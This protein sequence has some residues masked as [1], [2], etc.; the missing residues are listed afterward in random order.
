MQFIICLTSKKVQPTNRS[1]C[2]S[3]SNVKTCS[4]YIWFEKPCSPALQQYVRKSSVLA[5]NSRSSK[6]S[7]LWKRSSCQCSSTRAWLGSASRSDVEIFVNQTATKGFSVHV[8]AYPT[9]Q[10]TK[11]DPSK[12]RPISL[13]PL[14]L[15]F[16]DVSIRQQIRYNLTNY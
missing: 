2:L 11:N 15:H 3:H 16:K 7:T 4:E 5:Y 9:R 14:P 8:F 6:V 10:R 13:G 1:F 12:P